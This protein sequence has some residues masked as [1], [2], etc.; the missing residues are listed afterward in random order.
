M[1]NKRVRVNDGYQ[2]NSQNSKVQKGYQ[3]SAINTPP[4]PPPPLATTIP[5]TISPSNE[6]K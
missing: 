5:P 1:S 3:P 2:P 6:S 4:P